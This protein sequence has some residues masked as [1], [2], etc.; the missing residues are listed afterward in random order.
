MDNF[1]NKNTKIYDMENFN[2]NRE[3]EI[4]KTSNKN[5]LLLDDRDLIN[6][7]S[8]GNEQIDISNNNNIEENFGMPIFNGQILNN[9][10]SLLSNPYIQEDNNKN[11]FISNNINCNSMFEQIETEKKNKDDYFTNMAYNNN[12]SSISNYICKIE[13]DIIEFEY[14]LNREKINKFVVEIN[15]PFILGYLWKTILLLSKNPSSD[16]LLK[17]LGIKNKEIVVTDLKNHSEI[18][19]DFGT[20]EYIFPVTN[21]TV[22][23]NFINKI[24]EIYNLNIKT[25]Y[26]DNN[27]LKIISKFNIE[28]EI[29]NY[30][31]PKIVIDYMENYKENKFKFIELTDIPISITN[32]N[33]I[34]IIEILLESNMILGFIFDNKNKN[35]EILPYELMLKEKNMNVKVKKLVIPK[36]NKNKILDYGKRYT[37]ELQNIHLGEIIYGTLYNL[38]IKIMVGLTIST[39]QSSNKPLINKDI[40]EIEFY[41]IN[42]NCFFFIKNLNIPNKILLSG[43]INY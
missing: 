34:I 11:N 8:N 22:N 29:P 37:N 5:I 19:S 15:S 35:I 3:M 25:E 14:E 23:T 20:I 28:L 7:F 33:N 41:K 16:K 4:Y 30:Y 2:L 26:N 17:L 6:K 32:E 12:N 10:K 39:V 40:N 13:K 9:K 1:K 18:L 27:L 36:L 24:Q 42:H 38:D 43:I 31:N 21:Q